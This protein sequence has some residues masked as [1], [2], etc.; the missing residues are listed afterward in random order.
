LFTPSRI[1]ESKSYF[2]RA[3]MMVA[4]NP[5]LLERVKVARL[6]LL[7]TEMEIAKT[8]LFGPRGW[9]KRENGNFTIIKEK[10]ALLDT[11]VAVCKRNNVT[12]MNENGLT[13]DVYH[14]S[15][16]RF[17]DVS[18]VGNLAFE[19][20]VTCIPDP[21]KRYFEKGPATLTNGVRGTENYRMNWLGWEGIDVACTIDLGGVLNP[22]SASISTMHYPKSWIIHP[23]SITCKV[24]EDGKV[25][26]PISIV[27]PD[28]DLEKEPM[29][30]SF[31]FSLKGHPARFVLFEIEG[32]KALPE[33]HT[34][35]GNKSWVFVDEIVVK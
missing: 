23:K 11:F 13:V 9:F 16:L 5:V 6:P 17:I 28:R 19:K 33:W 32:S 12:H 14:E 34:Y 35:A 27:S 31:S 24:S 18:V 2:D 15:T 3:E 7:F 4:K 8:D 10:T 25:F 30:K 29:I 26:T 22:D 20:P 21:D 1:A